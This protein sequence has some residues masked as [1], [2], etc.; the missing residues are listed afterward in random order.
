RGDAGRTVEGR[1]SGLGSAKP[2]AGSGGGVVAARQAEAA[3]QAVEA[4]AG[5]GTNTEQLL[6]AVDQ[7]GSTATGLPPGADPMPA[8]AVREGVNAEGVL[9][10]WADNAAVVPQWRGSEGGLVYYPV[11]EVGSEF[12]QGVLPGG[13]G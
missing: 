10:S 9:R 11:P 5:S 6:S 3:G 8:A 7:R 2:A 1:S 12:E 4:P 13:S